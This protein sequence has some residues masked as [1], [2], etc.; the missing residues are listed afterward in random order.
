MGAILNTCNQADPDEARAIAGQDH[1][2]ALK[3][4]ND[5]YMEDPQRNAQ[6]KFRRRQTG[7][8]TADSHPL[9]LI[10]VLPTSMLILE[11]CMFA[12]FAQDYGTVVAS[13]TLSLLVISTFIV[14]QHFISHRIAH[15]LLGSLCLIGCGLG[16]VTGMHVEVNY[17]RLHSLLHHGGSR[18]YN[19]DPSEPAL[20]HA[21]AVVIGFSKGSAVD[22]TRATGMLLEEKAFCVAPVFNGREKGSTVE[23]WAVGTDCCLDRGDFRCDDA[24]NPTAR[25]GVVV[26]EEFTPMEFYQQ[27]LRKAEGLYGLTSAPGAL[28]LRWISDPD[29]LQQKLGS[30]A[31]TFMGIFTM[32]FFMLC[33]LFTLVLHNK[34]LREA[35]E[36]EHDNEFR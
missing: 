17:T 11:M 27:A 33:L 16:V 23:Y 7:R 36:L 35:Q 8:H 19:V 25:S 2:R 20:N 10:A 3:R 24:A 26:S 30:Q 14:W 29:A 28:F 13:L 6:D 5:M 22:T 32:V 34:L 31:A 15:L 21:D 18:Y 12:F 1:S 4:E 9:A